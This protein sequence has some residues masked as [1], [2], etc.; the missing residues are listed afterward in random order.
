M[1]LEEVFVG[2][3][4]WNTEIYLFSRKRRTPIRHH[5]S[6][7]FSYPPRTYDQEV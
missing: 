3:T 4:Y 2:Y 7:A 6:K 5:L 1:V